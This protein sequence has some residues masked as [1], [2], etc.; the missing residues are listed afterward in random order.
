MRVKCEAAKDGN[1]I[2][3]VAVVRTSL[4]V[5]WGKKMNYRIRRLLLCVVVC[6]AI[7]G[8]G[9]SSDTDNLPIEGFYA[10]QGS[11]GLERFKERLALAKTE[12]DDGYEVFYAAC[13]HSFA[14]TNSRLLEAKKTFNDGYEAFYACS[15]SSLEKAHQK[16]LRARDTVPGYEG[17]YAMQVWWGLDKF[18]ERLTSA[19][20]EYDDGYEVFYAASGR[21]FAAVN[22]RL[23]KAKQLF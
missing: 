16:M 23:V 10:M 5:A 3:A 14:K 1:S 18:K 2:W 6:S 4:R 20:E 21:G 15:S 22:E 7:S 19:Q 13:P 11:W 17:F 9:G 12:Y 8:C